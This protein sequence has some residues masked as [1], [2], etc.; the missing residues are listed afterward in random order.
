MPGHV[1]DFNRDLVQEFFWILL[2]AL[3]IFL[4][5]DFWLSSIIPVTWN[6]E[7]P[8]GVGGGGLPAIYMCLY[9]HSNNELLYSL[10]YF[11]VQE[12]F[13]SLLLTVTRKMLGLKPNKVQAIS[14]VSLAGL[15]TDTA[16]RQGSSRPRRSSKGSLSGSLHGFEQIEVC[17]SDQCTRVYTVLK[18]P[19]ILG[20]V[21]EFHF[22]LE[23][24]LNFCSSPFGLSKTEC[25]SWLREFNGNLYKACKLF[26]ANCELSF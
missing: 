3:G 21:L 13:C 26:Y 10:I 14:S 19:W 23:K 24:S 12:L 15:P 9:R 1:Q 16:F 17:S 11:Q 8:P 20:E 25:K 18:S 2:E 22:F 7:Y 4:G 6:P 5:L